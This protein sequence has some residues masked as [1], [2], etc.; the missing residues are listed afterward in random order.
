[1]TRLGS[2]RQRQVAE[3]ERELKETSI[4]GDLVFQSSQGLI[5]GL[6]MLDAYIGPLLGVMSPAIW[7]FAVTRSFGPLVYSLGSTLSGL[8][9]G[10]PAEPLQMLGS[11]QATESLR[12]PLLSE[13]SVGD[14]LSWWVTYL[15]KIIATVTDPA[16]FV[17]G[18]KRDYRPEK[19][20]QGLMGI[21]QLFRKVHSIQTGYRDAI[22]QRTLFF[23]VLDSLEHFLGPKLEKLCDLVYA[24]ET[25]D[26]LRRTMTDDAAVLLLYGAERGVKALES[27]QDGFFLARQSGR[28]TISVGNNSPLT[29]ATA[30]SRYIRLLRNGTHGFMGSSQKDE[31][32]TETLFAEHNGLIP[33]DLPLLANLYLMR[34][35]V[36]PETLRRNL[37]RQSARRR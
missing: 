23:T 6:F 10:A 24:R 27:L 8:R 2:D 32:L 31:K 28:S 21:E 3:I 12:Y 11:L 18:P 30:S 5:G 17:D 1:M 9:Q 19:Q 26:I 13:R 34:L 36:E 33:H 37:L 4:R 35:M 16:C 29:L 14:A 7:G 15:S 20:V 25:I 22:A